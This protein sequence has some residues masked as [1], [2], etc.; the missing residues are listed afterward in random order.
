LLVNVALETVESREGGG[1]RSGKAV[2][3]GDCSLGEG[4]ETTTGDDTAVPAG[5]RPSILVRELLRILEPEERL[6]VPSLTASL[7]PPTD[8]LMRLYNPLRP[9]CTSSMPFGSP[10]ATGAGGA[11][12]SSKVVSESECDADRCS[13]SSVSCSESREALAMA[14]A[15]AALGECAAAAIRA[16]SPQW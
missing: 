1:G 16:G 4:A 13:W 7:D 2:A 10:T 8:A 9:P 5:L 11:V 3:E 12:R 14:A 6:S 15:A